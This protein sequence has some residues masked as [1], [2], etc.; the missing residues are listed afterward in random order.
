MYSFVEIISR[1]ESSDEI[2]VAYTDAIELLYLYENDSTQICGW[3]GWIKYSDGSLGHSKKY[4]GTEDLS[5]MPKPSAI[6]LAKSTIMQSHNEW[7][8]KPEVEN[9]SLYY[10][11]TVN[12]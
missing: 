11:I 12:T 1:S 6:A 9:A 2:V 10:S 7:Q 5:H 3:E 8:E 4:Q